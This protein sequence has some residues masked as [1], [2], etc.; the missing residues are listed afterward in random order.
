MKNAWYVLLLLGACALC[1]TPAE[2]PA[3]PEVKQR[4]RVYRDS[5]QH[6]L[7]ND[8]ERAGYFAGLAAQLADSTG[9]DSLVITALINQGLVRMSSGEFSG[10]HQYF[11]SVLQHPQI[12]KYPKRLILAMGHKAN[13][14]HYEK[15]FDESEALFKRILDL[16]FLDG[17]RA[18]NIWINY[19]AM[20]MTKKDFEASVRALHSAD[21]LI[22]L[23]NGTANDRYTILYNQAATYLNLKN[24]PQAVRLFAE[25]LALAKSIP[26]QSKI[27]AIYNS[28]ANCYV[29]MDSLHA[30]PALLDSARRYNKNNA[31][32][33][34]VTDI[35]EADYF[36]QK[37]QYG[38]ALGYSRRALDA[39]NRLQDK[40]YLVQC[41]NQLLFIKNKLGNMEGAPALLETVFHDCPTCLSPFD[42][43]QFEGY[44]VLYE[45]WE[46]GP[47]EHYEKLRE[48][49]GHLDGYYRLRE[50]EAIHEQETKYQTAKKQLENEALRL[51]TA[52]QKQQ[53]IA[54]ALGLLALAAFALALFYRNR[55][56]NTRLRLHEVQKQQLEAENRELGAALDA[57]KRREIS[58]EQVLAKSIVLSNGR[59]LPLQ[60]ILYLE[61]A[62]DAV[63][64]H[65]PEERHFDGRLLKH[66]EEK[67]EQTGAFLRIHKKYIVNVSRISARPAYNAVHIG[68]G[69][70]L[71]VGRT[72]LER[73][74]A[75]FQA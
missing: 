4:L 68:E 8:L 44:A 53:I 37:N 73:M 62:G 47:R 27:P 10:A 20:L 66:W 16:P 19:G 64:F 41:S 9:V 43:L 29:E 24:Y 57:L 21:S 2:R 60:N 49:L 25:L 14:F 26:M 74:A 72:Y 18:V 28:L 65:T 12:R 56:K 69:I 52:A 70:V 3:S 51:R 38:Q 67:L 58:P 32:E 71:P 33:K 50:Q 31:V 5:L 61:S 6:Y 46:T 15:K 39:L 11:D 7:D 22:L 23:G 63:Y 17:E 36:C 40:Y 35:R 75:V 45:A 42:S 1:C 54:L 34:A 59:L 30:V 13:T 48:H 55:Q